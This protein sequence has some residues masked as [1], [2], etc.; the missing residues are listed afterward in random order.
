[1]F[2]R[3]KISF[4]H[5]VA[6][7]VLACSVMLLIASA[8]ADIDAPSS[9]PLAAPDANTEIESGE[10]QAKENRLI[11]IISILLILQTILV[12]GLQKS[13]IRY[14]KAKKELK[15]SYQLLEERVVERTEK[16]GA[17]N[18]KLYAEIAKQQATEA[19]LKQTKDYL[20]SMINSMS[21]I[22]IGVTPEGKITHWNSSAA[23]ITGTLAEEALGKTI[24]ELF[25]RLHISALTIAQV[26]DEDKPRITENVQLGQGSAAEYF[27]IAIYPHSSADISGAVVRIDDVTMKIKLENMMI[28]NEKMMSLGEL[29]AGMAHEINNPLGAILQG[30]QNI[31][32]RTSTELP[33]N[34]ATAEKLGT[35][36]EVLQRYL[37]ERKITKF[38][39]GI[40][41]AGERAAKIVTNMLEFSRST[42]RECKL[43]NLAILIDQVLELATSTFEL[44][45]EMQFKHIRIVRELSSD[46]PM[47]PCSPIEI[48]QVLLNLLKNASQAIAY[49][50][51]VIIDPRIS[52]RLYHDEDYAVLEV[53][54]N[55]PGMEESVSSH[56]F[57][58]FYTTKEV[59]QGTGLGLSV[60]YFIIS[61]HHNGTI[62]VDSHPGRGTR[63][64]I[65]LPLSQPD[66]TFI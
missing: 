34:H 62:E 9:Q 48:Q 10:N 41:E 2:N 37:T 59:G 18:E 61:E 31:Y 25:P 11:T 30:V 26:I 66:G 63:F 3:I 64:I 44:K 52:I 28:Q 17:I 20:R 36:I 22:L 39:D 46:M 24:D 35:S 13:R 54:D 27:S 56:I 15:T 45:T 4:Q 51:G 55:G 33:A 53:E 38:I 43:V 65:K 14:K 32:R 57:E 42:N 8:V 1:L 16:L 12:L 19:L 23:K 47:V 50:E 60:S 21:C 58:P 49:Q 5:W 29:A 7:L 6:T 40:Q